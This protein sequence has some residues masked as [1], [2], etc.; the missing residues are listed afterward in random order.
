[1][2]AALLTLFLIF[3]LFAL[4]FF[5]LFPLGR[6]AVYVPSSPEKTL[7]IVELSAAAP[8][9]KAADLGSG[10]GRV[11]IALA[12]RGAEAHGFEINP[13][14]VLVSRRAIR[15]AGLAGRAVVHWKS[16]WRVDLST[17][18]VI[19]VFQGSFIMKR[20]ERKLRRELRPGAR[21]ISDFWAFPT[22]S[23]E[24]RNGT[25][26]RYVVRSGTGQP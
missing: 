3:S 12:R 16:F 9:Q 13:V 14:L 24:S 21:V 8:G 6:G 2:T 15:R 10:D 19:T 11:L 25:T 26:Y 1:M 17:F 22:L 5:Y 4:V 20:L 23:P 18:D 7:L